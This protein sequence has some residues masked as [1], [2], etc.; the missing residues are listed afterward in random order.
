[1]VE[2][3]KQIL[4]S[5]EDMMKQQIERVVKSKDV[6]VIPDIKK[7]TAY[8]EILNEQQSKNIDVIVIGS[9]GKSGLIGHRIG[10]VAEKITREAKCPVILVRE[11]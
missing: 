10:S 11:K 3:E 2:L 4:A 9:H 8:R 7:G 5:S 1:M 6:E